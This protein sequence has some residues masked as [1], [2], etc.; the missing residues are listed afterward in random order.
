MPLINCP[1]C[2]RQISQQAEACPQCGHPNEQLPPKK[3]RG[4]LCYSCLKPAT[5]RCQQ[6]GKLSCAIHVTPF[7]VSRGDGS[8]NELLCQNCL[9]SAKEW[10]SIGLVIFLII[11]VLF[12]MFALSS[13]FR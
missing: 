7:Y 3:E 9:Q 11:L 8:G 1:A 2:N 6:C 12:F 4:P 5:T 13:S 10:K